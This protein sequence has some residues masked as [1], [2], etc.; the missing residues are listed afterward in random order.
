MNGKRLFCL[1]AAAALNT[2]FAAAGQRIVAPAPD[3]ARLTAEEKAWFETFQRGTFFA[4]GWREITAR[5]IEKTPQT[6]KEKIKQELDALG[7][8]IGCEWSRDNDIRK[9][10]NTMIAKWGNMLRQAEK[11]PE[12][13]PQVVASLNRRVLALLD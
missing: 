10:D 7:N 4:P 8:R 2:P 9:I 12:K 1:F 13:I 11:E 5:L 3:P 6:L